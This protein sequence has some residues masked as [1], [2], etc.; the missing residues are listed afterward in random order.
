M[1]VPSWTEMRSARNWVAFRQAR[2]ESVSGMWRN[3]D[4]ERGCLYEP[5][6][7]GYH[8]TFSG[9]TAQYVTVRG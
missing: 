3:N 8:N 5:M 7:I 6:M 9:W 1:H 4:R 2:V